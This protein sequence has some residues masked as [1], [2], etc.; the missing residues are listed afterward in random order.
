MGVPGRVGFTDGT[1]L[2][3]GCGSG[4]FL[5]L[6]PTPLWSRGLIGVELD[7]TTAAIATHLYPNADI[8][9]ESFAETRLPEGSVD[10]VIG[11]V[12][13][14]NVALHDP[15]HNPAGLA[16]H[17]HFIVKSLALTKPGGTVMVLTSR[18]TMDAQNPAARRAIA[19]QAVLLGALRLPNGAHQ[20]TAGTDVVTDL[21][22]LRR[23]DGTETG[24]EPDW[25]TSTP[26]D[27]GAGTAPMN[28]YFTAHPEHV[29]GRLGFDAGRY[30][31]GEVT[32]TATRTESGASALGVGLQQITVAAVAVGLG[33][34]PR[35]LTAPERGASAR[36]GG[37][38][39]RFVGHITATVTDSGTDTGF[40]VRRPVGVDE[41]LVVPRSQ[42]PE[43]RALLGLR[44]GVVA[45]LEAE[46]A[47]VEDTQALRGLRSDLAAVYTRYAA[48]FGP[49]N[50]VGQRRTGR[51]DP[52]TGVERMAQVRPPVMRVFA[53]DPFSA[54][55]RALEVYDAQSQTAVGAAILSQRVVAPR[56]P[57]LGADTPADAAAICRDT[58]GELRL[59]EI[60]RLLGVDP[61]T[62]RTQLGD[63]VFDDPETGRLLPAAEYLSGNVRTR[64][65]AAT[66]ASREA[67]A[68]GGDDPWA[69]NVAALTEVVPVDLEP[70]DID[71][72]LGA[73]WID[74][75]DVQVFL[76]EILADRSV[77]VVHTVGA[78]WKVTGGR[79]GVLATD[80]WGTDRLPA[81]QL[82]QSLLR[83][84]PIRV[85]DEQE[86]GSRVFNPTAT[87]A[88]QEKT[89]ALGERFSE[90]V[91]EDPARAQRLA[92]TYN[93][94]FNAIV[95]RHY[96][97]DHMSLPGLA[98]SWTPRPHQLSAVA[99]MIAEPNAGLFHEV[100]AGK[101]AE[102]AMGVMELRR[103]GLVRKPAIVVP[104]HMLDQFSGEFL[105]LYPRARVLAAGSDDL[106]GDKRRDFVA[107]TTTGEWD[108]VIMTRTAFTR[109]DVSHDTVRAYQ[110]VELGAHREALTQLLGT[111]DA[112]MTIK[113]L[114]KHLLGQEQKLKAKLD[115][116]TDPG[117]TFEQ[118]GIDYLVVD[119]LH[120]YKNLATP[121]NM[122]DAAIEGSE[123]AQ[124][125]HMK[126]GYLRSR[127]NGRAMT[128]ATAT[129][130]ANSITEAYVMQR[131]LRPDLLTAAGVHDFDTWA[132][133]FGTTVS[134]M[135]MSPDGGSWRMKARFAKF[136]NVPEFLRL[137]HV[138]ADVKTAEDL[139]LPT[140]DLAV[141][142]DGQRAPE[143]VVIAPSQAQAQFVTSLGD[144]AEAV[145]NGSVDP[146]EDNMLKISS[147]GRAAALDLRLL[148]HVVAENA[149]R[150]DPTLLE[151]DGPTKLAVAADRINTIWA[152]NTD[153]VYTA[154][155]GG[156]HPR[157]GSL[158]LV[159]SDLG[160]PREGFNAY[161]ELRELLVARG[162]PAEQVAF[163]HSA[164]N[165]REKAQ[166]FDA[167][168]TG[169]VQ[170]L[171]GSTAKMGVGTNVQAR[172]IALHHLDCPWRP[173]DL[174][175]RDGRVIR[176]GN[177]NPEVQVIRYVTE[178]AFDTYSWQTV[179]RKARFIAQVMR[180]RLDSREIEDIGDAALSYSEVK[181]LASGD[182][183]V[184]EKAA[185]D[186]TLAGL[187]RLRRAHT[188][189]QT[190]LRHQ[191]RTTT[192]QLGYLQAQVAPLQ[193]AIAA[194]TPTKGELFTAT[195]GGGTYDERAAAAAAFTHLLAPRL[196]THT[197]RVPFLAGTVAEIGGFHGVA[198]IEE[199]RQG[200]VA[201]VT[202][203]G[204]P[205]RAV[206][207]TAR[208]LAQPGP[209]LIVRLE[210]SLATMDRNLVDVH[211]DI[212]TTTT[213]LARAQARVGAP[214]DKADQLTAARARR[215]EIAE[216][217]AP[218]P[219]AGTG[220]PAWVTALGPRPAT[221]PQAQN[222]DITVSMVAAYR[223]Q[224]PVPDTAL[225]QPLGPAPAQGSDQAAAFLACYRQWA[226]TA[227]DAAAQQPPP[228]SARTARPT[229]TTTP[230]TLG[231]DG[232]TD[233]HGFGHGAGYLDRQRRDHRY[234]NS[235]H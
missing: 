127:H 72:R 217:M 225:Q 111:P 118:T 175:Q 65:V 126:V 113:R 190:N 76:R 25:E 100:G 162:I 86:D 185:A 135:E 205:A 75:D 53:S 161:D 21:L 124:D 160:T 146:T 133:T 16:M 20:R 66:D 91:W 231:Q 206:T 56:T 142:P 223:A 79:S 80:E 73:A 210:N 132:A 17:N 125:L 234:L 52:D 229:T 42:Q 64:L 200:N 169:A 77:T 170:V 13:F 71:A 38:V 49:L 46:A 172:A 85:S 55:V 177:Q 2:E 97:T 141:R 95:L 37:R 68:S 155:G 110:A 84:A 60:G 145:R 167:A 226:L 104:N 184:L 40:S 54:T 134:E 8:R 57:R 138:A 120:D 26:V 147:E 96:D 27:L 191:V 230:M 222:F 35:E 44:D 99:R 6:A 166:L 182:P 69:G 156:D 232:I 82:A 128:G 101:T 24:P 48:T 15:V 89:T 4:T 216:R 3:P 92:R 149:E 235:G 43:L 136:R 41:D 130:I 39:D 121:S 11:N 50:R 9:T 59:A 112:G 5:G 194:R 34:H 122:R 81:T 94:T 31:S 183:L 90:W 106:A 117:V 108:A 29:L 144:R 51:V 109:L 47:T 83:Q 1:V 22:V 165:D 154:P 192:T 140:P 61:A 18:Y 157:T 137:W 202:F 212:T 174:S 78:D 143:T 215:D 189:S 209:G 181:A 218:A 213:E 198:M 28:T 32:V 67:V 197:G 74:A 188:Q 116:P 151:V 33:H 195:V 107:R 158:Q 123:R 179:E 220:L 199:T 168:R 115:R 204:C 19:E 45:L 58:H 139:N 36:V 171:V 176:Q 219:Q 7:P 187:E 224:Y 211:A 150:N 30:A 23:R 228:R 131:Y 105:Q 214:F 178:A 227:P 196:L 12:P 180:G 129:P 152:A 103:L 163:I 153:R 193:Q 203:T 102:M 98:S 148:P 207:Y 70:G 10:A 114:E 88:A 186:N 201:S 63:L 159:F 208:D 93:D 173:A 87:A 233:D 164:R 221:E 119:E 62:A 14:A